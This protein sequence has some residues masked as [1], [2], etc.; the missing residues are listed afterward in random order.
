MEY[1]AILEA[2]SIIPRHAY[3]VIESDSK[4]SV[5]GIATFRKRREK[6]GW[7]KDD[8]QEVINAATIEPL[9]REVNQH[10]IGFRK[11]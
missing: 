10:W 8:G 3:V 1:L 2:L 6:N 9:T 4:R 11:G 7:R 5:D